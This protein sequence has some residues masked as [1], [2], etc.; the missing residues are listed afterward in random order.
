MKSFRLSGLLIGG[1]IL[2]AAS[3]PV[4]AVGLE[5]RTAVQSQITA[6]VSPTITGTLPTW[7]SDIVV[8]VAT[9]Q[10]IKNGSVD[11]FF[12]DY[13]QVIV[14]NGNWSLNLQSN[15]YGLVAGVYD[16]YVASEC[17]YS[18]DYSNPLYEDIHYGAISI[19]P[20][21]CDSYCVPV[22]RFYNIKNGAH[23]YTT[24]ENEKRDVLDYADYRFEGIVSYAKD[25][26]TTLPGMIPVYRFYNFKQGVHFYTANQAEATNVNNNMTSTFRYEGIAYQTYAVPQSSTAPVYR[27][28][29]F[30]Q[31][32]HFYTA[33]QAEA[34][35]VNDHLFSTYRYEGVSYYV[36]H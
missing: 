2:F 21:S 29:K 26:R 15:N 7:C 31:G 13:G 19:I 36:I 4:S 10:A 6:T 32:V 23:F 25:Y 1:V 34:S 30:G 5:G 33:D 17:G 9:S 20:S 11:F 28:Y 16:V 18:G 8:G 14:S 24:T 3:A 35:Y 22:Y 12:S 27:F